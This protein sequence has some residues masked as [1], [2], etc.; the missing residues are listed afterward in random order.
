MNIQLFHDMKR[1]AQYVLRYR[2]LLIITMVMMLIVGLTTAG[3][4][5]LIKWLMDTII[6]AGQTEKIPLFLMIVLV[7]YVTRSLCMFGSSYYSRWIGAGTVHRIREKVISHILAQALPYFTK[8]PSGQL[9]ARFLHDAERLEL[10]LTHAFTDL[11]MESFKALAVL[12]YVWILNWR[13]TLFTSVILPIMVSPIYIFGKRLRQTTLAWHENLAELNERFMNTV[14]GIQTVQAYGGEEYERKALV[15]LSEKVLDIRRKVIQWQAL[16]SPFVELAMG[17]GIVL[18][19][20]V[21]VHEIQKGA[22]TPGGFTSFIAGLLLIYT[23]LRKLSRA[24]ANLHEMSSALD[25]LEE[26]LSV[27]LHIEEKPDALECPPLRKGITFENVTFVYPGSEKPVLEQ[28]SLSIPRGIIFALV[29]PSGAGKSTLVQ[30]IPRFYD[31][32]EGK[33]LW[34]DVP[35]HTF[36]VRSLRRR[37]GWVSQSPFIFPATIAENIA[38]GQPDV[39]FEVIQR[40]ARQ[41]GADEFIRDLPDGYQTRLGPGGQALSMGQT[42]RIALARALLHEPDILILDEATS[43]LD[44]VH[45][46]AFQETL[47]RLKGACTIIIIAHRWSSVRIAERIALISHGR[48]LEVGSHDELYAR[49]DLYKRLWEVQWQRAQSIR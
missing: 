5:A 23:P 1:I 11:F 46:Q 37:I 4:N 39:P 15:R 2:F 44:V 19:L 28:I 49:S 27:Q 29:G 45:E 14:S 22:L 17:V 30:L 13:L 36:R 10:G 43:S 38:Y 33:V 3:M 18:M 9:S 26:L 21:G 34:D 6:I 8:Y 24:H 16:H 48:I 31:V 42:Q 47:L 41:A 40:A 12:V 20:I 7:L 25:R 32:S 35:L